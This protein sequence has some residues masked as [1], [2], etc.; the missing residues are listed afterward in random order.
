VQANRF[1]V[2]DGRG[3]LSLIL[4][5]EI[6][7]PT[8]LYGVGDE[9]GLTPPSA[10]RRRRAKP[11]PSTQHR[12]KEADL[13]QPLL[14]AQDTRIGLK[15]PI[16][17]LDACRSITISAMVG[18]TNVNRHDLL[19]WAKMITASSELPRLLR[20]LILETG[21][22]VMQLGFPAGEG[23]ALGGWDGT[24]VAAEPS[25]FIPAGLSVWELSVEGAVRAKAD[26]DYEK[27]NATPDGSPTSGCTYVAVALRPWRDRQA[28]ATARR[29]EGTWKDVRVL[30][31]LFWQFECLKIGQRPQ[32]GKIGFPSQNT[33]HRG[34][35]CDTSLLQGFPPTRSESW[36]LVSGRLSSAVGNRYTHRWWDCT[37]RF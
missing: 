25:P 3:E 33:N 23:V 12:V 36:L 20:R 35:R 1:V 16:Y 37:A 18:L 6:H 19:Q 8:Q 13:Q 7:E 29:V 31:A 2:R 15:A 21:R 14:H 24:L 30:G 10:R 5:D 11:S 4:T 26:A 28:W 32:P 22:G 17:S 34:S 9:N 27:R